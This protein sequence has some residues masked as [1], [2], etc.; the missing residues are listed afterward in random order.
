ML[1]REPRASKLQVVAWVSLG[2]LVPVSVGRS[3]RVTREMLTL[4]TWKILAPA[5]SLQLYTLVCVWVEQLPS[6]ITARA[7]LLLPLT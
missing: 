6:N 4:F 3:V 7:D 2:L 5:P 1:P